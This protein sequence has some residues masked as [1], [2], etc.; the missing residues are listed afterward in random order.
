MSDFHHGFGPMPDE[1]LNGFIY[2]VLWRSGYRCFHSILMT[3]GWGDKPSVPLAAKHEFNFL[4]RYLKL[5]LYEKTFRQEKN[6]LSIFSNPI[7]HVNNF[8]K[9]FSPIK[10]VKSCGNPIQIKFCRKCIDVQIKESGFSYFKNEW[11]NE[12]F[13]KSHQTVLHAIDPRVNRKEIFEV[14]QCILSG[15]CVDKYLC[16]ILDGFHAHTSM[17]LSKSEVKFA[18]CTKPLLINYLKSKSTCYPDG[19]TELVDYGYL[20]KQERYATIK[21]KRSE[22]IKFSLEEHLDFYLEFDYDSIN[23]FLV[24][25]LKLQSFSPAKANLH[26]RMYKLWKDR[27]S[28]C[29]L[30]KI[31]INFG[32]MCPV[33]E[34]SQVY[35]KK[36]VSLL[37]AYIPPKNICDEKLSEMIDKVYSYQV[38][39]GVREGEILV[40]KDIKKSELHSSYG[41]E[42]AYYE[43][44]SK[45][46]R[47][48]NF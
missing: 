40:R 10:D 35:F 14:V 17:P 1:S 48:L 34:Q 11:L 33:A 45:V 2:R 15:N 27:K 3:G 23:K 43:Y 39:I 4:D 46:L 37:H 16:K 30:C 18:P 21:Y 38:H 25:H 8:E 7:S 6:Q 47:D 9:T 19:Y 29:S 22:E 36:A 44:V 26:K 24:E 28:N 31:N 5:D 13:C 20:T 41:G 32:E 42:K 12:D